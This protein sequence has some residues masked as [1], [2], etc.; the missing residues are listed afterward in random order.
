[1][2][3]PARSP[4]PTLSVR[5]VQCSVQRARVG[6]L[7]HGRELVDRAAAGHARGLLARTVLRE[8]LP[9]NAHLSAPGSISSAG[10][11]IAARGAEARCSM[12]AEAGAGTHK[13]RDARGLAKWQLGQ[14]D[15]AHGRCHLHL[16]HKAACQ[17]PQAST[18]TDS[19]DDFGVR[20]SP[21]TRQGPRSKAQRKDKNSSAIRGQHT[22]TQRH[23]LRGPLLRGSWAPRR[24][25]LLPR[26]SPRWLV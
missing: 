13:L 8:D 12:D 1:M 21:L 26:S 11:R 16:A 25:F 15:L 14:L 17:S 4:C 2:V 7:A 9:H 18:A 23:A 22:Q 3:L 20:P 5:P 24:C 10:L 6:G 19:L